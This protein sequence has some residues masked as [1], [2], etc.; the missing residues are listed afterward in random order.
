MPDAK[1]QSMAALT[2]AALK[3]RARRSFLIR[4]GRITTTTSFILC[5]CGMIL[6]DQER[7]S[8]LCLPLAADLLTIDEILLDRT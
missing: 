3:Q 1:K 8:H 2:Y 4:G 5:S 6:A 7:F